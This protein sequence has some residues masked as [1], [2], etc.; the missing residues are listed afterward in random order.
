MSLVLF[1]TTVVSAAEFGWLIDKEIGNGREEVFNDN[2]NISFSWNR[3]FFTEIRDVELGVGDSITFL[4]ISEGSVIDLYR[5]TTVRT[6]IQVFGWSDSDLRGVEMD[7]TI[8]VDGHY[9]PLEARTLH[10]PLTITA[11]RADDV[12][13]VQYRINRASDVQPEIKYNAALNSDGNRLAVA[14]QNG[15]NSVTR[16]YE[17]D[18]SS[19]IQLGEDVR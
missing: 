6:N 10:G 7:V 14:Q 17:Y 5:E 15:T 2:G 4:S 12:E 8:K 13:S 16:V 19:W 11:V 1:A 18:G 9:V 3:N